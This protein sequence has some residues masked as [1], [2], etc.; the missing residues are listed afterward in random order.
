MIS[1]EYGLKTI[2]TA[3]IQSGADVN[4]ANS[5]DERGES[6]N[7][8]VLMHAVCGGNVDI[9]TTLIAS[10]AKLDTQDHVSP[11]VIVQ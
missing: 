7:G 8:T 4:A 9:L 5:A 3:L 2:A 11:C 6:D 1:A 10:G